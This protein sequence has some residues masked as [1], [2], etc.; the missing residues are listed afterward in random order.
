MN[1]D[2]DEIQKN[3]SPRVR[4]HFYYHYLFKFGDLDWTSQKTKEKQKHRTI[5]II[6][7]KNILRNSIKTDSKN[8]E[9]GLS[10]CN[11][12]LKTLLIW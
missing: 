10:S 9:T 3:L 1:Y 6:H 8:D 2:K 11:E 4:L 12:S 5:N 7:T